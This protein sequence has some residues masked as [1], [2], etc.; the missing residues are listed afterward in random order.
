VILRCPHCGMIGGHDRTAF[1]GH[2]VACPSCERPFAWREARVSPKPGTEDG[3]RVRGETA[4]SDEEQRRRKM[5]ALRQIIYSLAAVTV[6]GASNGLAQE[7]EPQALVV[8][9]INL[10]AGDALHQDMA[11]SGGDSNALLPG[12][13]VQYRLVFTNVTEAPVRSVE[14]TDPVPPGLT[15]VTQSARSDRSDVVVEYSVDGGTTYSQQPTVEQVV[16][17][18]RRLVPAAP[19]SYTHVRWRIEGWVQPGAQVTAEF[20]AELREAEPITKSGK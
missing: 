15:Y 19:E 9:A 8:T 13:V 17:G 3:N 11:R 14:F 12:D 5:R 4:D 10:M 6:L 18:Q 20:R 2:W 7:A 16:G 1:F